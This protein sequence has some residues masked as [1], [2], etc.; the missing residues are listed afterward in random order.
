M[1]IKQSTDLYKADQKS[2]ID[3]KWYEIL[4]YTPFLLGILL[5]LSLRILRRKNTSGVNKQRA[6]KLAHKDL[7]KVN[8]MLKKDDSN[9]FYI[10]LEQVL[11]GYFDEK[12]EY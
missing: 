1:Y 8:K 11:F 12:V 4:L 6:A 5:L 9:G 7:K 2:F 3:S 10:E